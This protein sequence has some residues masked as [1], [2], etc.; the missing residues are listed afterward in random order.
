MGGRCF[1]CEWTGD[2]VDVYTLLLCFVCTFISKAFSVCWN[3]CSVLPR[4]TQ[5][6]T[7]T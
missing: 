1:D 6:M 7:I 4:S 5:S 2:C 3:R